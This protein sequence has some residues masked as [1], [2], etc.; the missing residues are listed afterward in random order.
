MSSTR[1]LLCT[2]YSTV[3]VLLRRKLLPGTFVYGYTCHFCVRYSIIRVHEHPVPGTQ[4]YRVQRYSTS[5]VY[6]Q[7][8]AR[9]SLYGIQ[10]SL[11]NQN[12]NGSGDLEIVRYI[13]NLLWA[14]SRALIRH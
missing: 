9:N 13:D 11:L 4:K 2:V 1:V 12:D 10:L 3:L 14:R 8:H 6:I 7:S 5:T